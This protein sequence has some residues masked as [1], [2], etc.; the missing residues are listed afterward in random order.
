MKEYNYRSITEN[1]IRN[2]IVEIDGKNIL[3]RI[4][5][6][7][8]ENIPK[9]LYKYYRCNKESFAV[10]KKNN[11]W[12][13]DPSTF[14]DPFDTSHLLWEA[15]NFPFQEIKKLLKNILTPEIVAKCNNKNQLRELFFM[16]I[17]DFVG[18]FCLNEGLNEDP[19]WAYYGDD[20][21]GFCI[22]FKTDILTKDWHSEPLKLQYLEHEEFIGKQL[23]HLNDDIITDLYNLL[24]SLI[25]WAT[26]K[27]KNWVH[28]NEWRY[29]FWIRPFEHDS[30]LKQYSP[31]A[32]DSIILGYKFFGKTK[33]EYLSKGIFKYSFEESWESDKNDNNY[34]FEII[35]HLKDLNRYSLFQIALDDEMK[36]FHQKIEIKEINDNFVKIWYDF[37]EDQISEMDAHI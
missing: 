13:S 36:L 24:P 35:K 26:V 33:N 30:R 14:N 16:V 8:Q 6:T 1:E 23:L 22:K 18:L 28:E 27:K 37:P 29:L 32:I 31:N 7:P 15:K 34:T 12:A 11:I 20:H 2:H 10:L 4:E 3:G 19:F 21:K 17:K 25:R 9:S 5:Y